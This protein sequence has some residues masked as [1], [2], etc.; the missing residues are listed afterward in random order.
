MAENNIMKKED[1]LESELN[2]LYKLASTISDAL[3]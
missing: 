1:I 3:Y 2:H